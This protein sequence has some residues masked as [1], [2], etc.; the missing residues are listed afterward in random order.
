MLLNRAI[1][2]RGILRRLTSSGLSTRMASTVIGDSGRSYNLGA[3]LQHHPVSST[4]SI[5][6]AQYVR[7]MHQVS[8]RIVNVEIIFQF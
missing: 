2:C 3:A 7:L 8:L 4:P 1:G 5:F 6:K